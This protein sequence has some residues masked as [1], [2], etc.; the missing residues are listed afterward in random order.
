MTTSETIPAIPDVL[1]E[2]D[3]I[4]GILLA[5]K[6]IAEIR[7]GRRGD[8]NQR[9]IT[10]AELVDYLN[11]NDQLVVIATTAGH[12]HDALYSVL[13]HNHEG[14]YAEI[15]DVEGVYALVVHDHDGLYAA[16]KHRHDELYS[17][18]HH[19]HDGEYATV[20]HDHDQFQIT[21]KLTIENEAAAW[22]FSIL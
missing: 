12:N 4:R 15:V 22:W 7:N 6:Q 17:K 2:D 3:E 20:Y 18:L 14:L 16:L 11:G 5:L 19:R 8:I 10:Y 9:F 21:K 13:S 1:I